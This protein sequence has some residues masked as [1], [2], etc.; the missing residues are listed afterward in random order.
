MFVKIVKIKK[1]KLIWITATKITTC[2][3][4]KLLL[5]IQQKLLIML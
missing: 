5:P 3:F 1:D 2:Y 4:V